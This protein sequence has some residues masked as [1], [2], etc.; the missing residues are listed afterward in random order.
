MRGLRY[1]FLASLFFLSDRNHD[2]GFIRRRRRFLLA[3][4]GERFMLQ[5]AD[6]SF[7]VFD[8]IDHLVDGGGYKGGSAI[9][10]DE[11]M[12]EIIEPVH[13]KVDVVFGGHGLFYFGDIRGVFNDGCRQS[14]DVG[15]G[16]EVFEV[17]FLSLI[18]I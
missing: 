2:G 14:A 8:R 4:S 9:H 16:G 18:H 5:D 12:R 17:I 6:A 3:G 10:H 15:F 11:F 13:E 1:W 7:E